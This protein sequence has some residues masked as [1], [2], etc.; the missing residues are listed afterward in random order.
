M[1]SSVYSTVCVELAYNMVVGSI[2]N[3][4][5]AIRII[6]NKYV[7]CVLLYHIVF[8]MIFVSLENNS[9]TE[10]ISFSIFKTKKMLKSWVFY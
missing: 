1:S 10:F 2:L 6:K 5:N 7:F 3:N 9:N 4:S 8:S